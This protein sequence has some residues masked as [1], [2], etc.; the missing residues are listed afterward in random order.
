MTANPFMATSN[1]ARGSPSRLPA[2]FHA[3]FV[4]GLAG[5]SG[6]ILHA[7]CLLL[8]AHLAAR[9]SLRAVAGREKARKHQRSQQILMTSPLV[10]EVKNPQLLALAVLSSAARNPL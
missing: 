8:A 7:R 10:V 6:I 1:P 9:L 3:H 4:F 2:R 5:R